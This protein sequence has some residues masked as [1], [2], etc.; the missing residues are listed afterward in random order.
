MEWIAFRSYL[1]SMQPQHVTLKKHLK[2]HTHYII[3]EF[4]KLPSVAFSP[5]KCMG[6]HTLNRL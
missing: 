3:N 4:P 5:V 2:K 6:K 1:K